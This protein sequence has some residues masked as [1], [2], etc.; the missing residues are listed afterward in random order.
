MFYINHVGAQTELIFD[1]GSIVMSPDGKLH[2]ELPY[3]DECI[4]HYDLE[5]VI[6]SQEIF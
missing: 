4:R 1:G 6:K 2:D 5:E 3:F